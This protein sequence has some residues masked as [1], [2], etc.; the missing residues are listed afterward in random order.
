[1]PVHHSHKKAYFVALREGVFAW[2]PAGLASVK[3][4]LRAHLL[5]TRPWSGA[6]SAI[7]AAITAEIEA[8]MYYDAKYFTDRVRRCVLPAA[9][10]YKRVRAVF[11]FYGQQLDMKTG[12]PLFGKV[13]PWFLGGWF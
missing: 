7:A 12:L 2:D 6:P 8:K 10:L 3:V 9:A 4:K 11:A 1:V 5:A 13:S